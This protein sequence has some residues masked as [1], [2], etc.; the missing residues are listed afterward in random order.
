MY[1]SALLFPF[2]VST[3]GNMGS[4]SYDFIAF[5]CT[6]VSVFHVDVQSIF[7][8]RKCI[9]FGRSCF[10]LKTNPTLHVIFTF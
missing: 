8:Q 5:I 6:R 4:L 3:D 7:S 1:L 10:T 9:Q 2:L